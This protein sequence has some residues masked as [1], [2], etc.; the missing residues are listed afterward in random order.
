MA[1]RAEKRLK[2]VT[3][4][5]EVP[6]ITVALTTPFERTDEGL[7]DGGVDVEGLKR[8][9]RWVL[10]QVPAV[11]EHLLH[12]YVHAWMNARRG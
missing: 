10:E 12:A 8:S 6:R 1:Q 7:D 9:C 3:P 5:R 11:Q 2:N 4:R